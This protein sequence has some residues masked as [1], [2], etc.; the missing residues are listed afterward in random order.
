MP[1][2]AITPGEPAGIGPELAIML[3]HE[4]FDCEL[5]AIADPQL[6]EQTAQNIGIETKL[7]EANGSKHKAGTLNYIPVPL[8]CNV[9]PGHPDVRNAAY[10]LKTLDIAT[11]GCLNNQ[12]D[13]MVTGPV[14]KSIINEAGIP[15]SGHTEYLAA[16]CGSDLPVMMLASSDLRVT[17][18]STHIPLSAVSAYI[19]RD[20]IVKNC[21]DHSP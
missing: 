10:V 2:I 7:I 16:H 1:N 11:Q 6:L 15:F 21:F 20:R 13:A 19:D 4:N 14:Q 18:Y 12:F 3:A 8:Q 17:L 5:I 9:I